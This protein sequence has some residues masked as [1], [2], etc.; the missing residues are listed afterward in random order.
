MCN[1]GNYDG[2]VSSL[3]SDQGKIIFVI[4]FY[5]FVYLN[6]VLALHV[7]LLCPFELCNL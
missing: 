7:C 3:V 1:I 5:L 4:Y 6:A 2:S